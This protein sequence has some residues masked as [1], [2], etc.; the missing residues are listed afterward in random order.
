MGIK[1]QAKATN[2][3]MA[4]Y[5]KQIR[6][7]ENYTMRA[8]ADMI[9]K[10]HSFIGKMELCSRRLDVGEFIYYCRVMKKDPVIVLEAIMAPDEV[11]VS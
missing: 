2:E 4:A 8:L 6:H 1:N 3:K 10:P 11:M 9:D 5:L 7:E